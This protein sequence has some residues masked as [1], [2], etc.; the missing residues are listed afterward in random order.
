MAT[1]NISGSKSKAT[2]GGNPRPK[3]AGNSKR[4]DATISRPSQDKQNFRS[5]R[6]PSGIDSEHHDRYDADLKRSHKRPA[7]PRNAAKRSSR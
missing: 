4:K 3:G 2:G 5:K 6:N 1:R 7:S